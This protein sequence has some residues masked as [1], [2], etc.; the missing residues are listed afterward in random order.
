MFCWAGAVQAQPGFTRNYAYR[1]FSTRD[2]LAQMQVT[3]VFQDSDGYMWFGTKVGVS[4]YDGVSFKNYTMDNGMP[5]GEV[6]SIT[7]YEDKIIFVMPNCLVLLHPDEKIKVINL[8]RNLSIES[9]FFFQSVYSLE[10]NRL[11]L[12]NILKTPRSPG[13]YRLSCYELSLDTYR[14]RKVHEFAQEEHFLKSKNNKIITDQAVYE[15][16][17][18]KSCI[19]QTDR[20]PVQSVNVLCDNDMKTFYFNRQGEKIIKYRKNPD[21]WIITDSISTMNVRNGISEKMILINDAELLYIAGKKLKFWPDRDIDINISDV[22]ITGFYLDREQNCWII[23]D[24]GIYKLFNF[25]IEENRLGLGTQDKIW[26]VVEGNDHTMWFGSFM[27]GLWKLTPG[28]KLE[29]IKLNVHMWAAQYFNSIKTKNGDLYFPFGSGIARY[30]DGR[31][32]FSDYKLPVLSTYFDNETGTLF[33]STEDTLQNRG[34]MTGFGANEKFYPWNKRFIISIEKDCKN[35]IRVG[36]FTGQGVFTGDKIVADTTRRQYQG[37]VSMATDDNRRL[38]KGTERG[39]YAELDDGREYRVAGN[40]IKNLVLSL[41]NYRNKYLIVGELTKLYIVDIENMKSYTR[42]IVY[43]IGYDAGFTGLESGQNGMC[44]DHNGD[45]WMT[46]ATCVLKFNPEK[47]VQSQIRVMPPIRVA[48]ILYSDD[49][50]NWEQRILPKKKNQSASDN[51]QDVLH[52]S[53]SDKFL[54][55]EYI[56]NSIS[57]PR[58]LKFRYRLRGFSDQWSQ[59]QSDKTAEFTNIGSGKYRFEVQCNLDGEKW[60]PVAY[61]PEIHILSSLWLRWYA[62]LFYVLLL[63]LF[64][65]GVVYVFFRR[66]EKRLTEKMQRLKLENELQ[67]RTLHSKVLPHFAKN[68]L[69]AIARYAMDDNRKAGKYIAMFS[70]FMQSTLENADRNFNTIREELDYINNYLQLEKMRFNDRLTYE[71]DVETDVDE[72]IQ[73]PAMILHTYCDNAIRHGIVNKQGNG[74]LKIHVKK[75]GHGTLVSVADN[76]IGR[77]R[78]TELGTQGNQIGLNLVQEQ[79]EFYNSNNEVKMTQNITDLYN[80]AGHPAGTRIDFFIPDGFRFS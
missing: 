41:L 62:F 69:T 64:F 20:L 73:I 48:K 53:A 74:S 17:P 15:Y 43:E 31:F 45:V 1:Y 21:G 5:F 32:E 34:L 72:Q 65:S 59:P 66:R 71:I 36:S 75:T 52:L 26:S 38:W 37:V 44:I 67:F 30:T 60:S 35:R 7:E 14:M 47:L 12:F 6:I 63:V 10:N 24:D 19:V 16:D 18:V 56:A 54:R 76:G 28:G 51:Q 40:S 39:L 77:K 25:V 79:L 70:N 4:R 13:V 22:F 8:P 46:T 68:V 80:D 55:F 9:Y 23:T 2:G 11:L 50:V 78:S 3:C 49:N 57:A 33:R 58:S 29:N 61:S 42:P 27:K